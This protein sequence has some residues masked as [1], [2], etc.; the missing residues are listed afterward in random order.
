MRQVGVDRSNDEDT[1]IK[2]PTTDS[3]DDLGF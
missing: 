2:L 1:T 3:T